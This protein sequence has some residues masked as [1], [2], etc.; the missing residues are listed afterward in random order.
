[1]R[2]ST[3]AVPI[4]PRPAS[5]SSLRLNC[6]CQVIG[7][8]CEC[9]NP[10][11]ALHWLK[12]GKPVKSNGR[13]KTQSPGV[14]LI[15]QLGLDDAGYYQCIADNALGTACATAKLS[16]IVR[17][18]LPSPPHQYT[19]TMTDKMRKKNPENHIVGFLMNLLANYG[20]K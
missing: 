17:E 8:I 16:V 14:L 10:P 13:V 19:S 3:S 18:G 12:N 4:N 1:M 2:G 20:G 7:R 9:E 6:M 5:L 15:N 11:P